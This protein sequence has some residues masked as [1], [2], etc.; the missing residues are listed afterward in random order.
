MAPLAKDAGAEIPLKNNEK[1][2][3]TT[4]KIPERITGRSGKMRFLLSVV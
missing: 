3:P 1:A 4:S 2:H